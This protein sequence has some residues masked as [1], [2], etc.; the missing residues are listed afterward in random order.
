MLEVGAKII[1]RGTQW[2]ICGAKGIVDIGP[3]LMQ[4]STQ[5]IEIPFPS[6][7]LLNPLSAARSLFFCYIF[8]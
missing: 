4:G 6:Q 7:M 3:T 8:L 2:W 1:A 5:N